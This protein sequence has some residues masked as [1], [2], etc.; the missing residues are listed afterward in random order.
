MDIGTAGHTLCVAT[1]LLGED[2]FW[3]GDVWDHSWAVNIPTT[4]GKHVGFLFSEVVNRTLKRVYESGV[5]L[6]KED[7]LSSFHRTWLTSNRERK[8]KGDFGRI[9]NM[10]CLIDNSPHIKL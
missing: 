10:S 6:Q 1:K 3:M 8:G 5:K 9:E 2:Q 4:T 7:Q